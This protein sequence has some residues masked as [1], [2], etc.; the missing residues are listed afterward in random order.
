MILVRTGKRHPLLQ[1]LL[2]VSFEG[3]HRARRMLDLTPL[4]LTL[5]LAEY[6]AASLAYQGTALTQ[7]AS[8]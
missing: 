8:L 4:T 3:A 1:L 7:D 2:T 5:S 6:V